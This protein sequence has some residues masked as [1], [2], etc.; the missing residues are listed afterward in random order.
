M[1][2][3]L[4]TVRAVR[5]IMALGAGLSIGIAAAGVLAVLNGVQT[6]GAVMMLYGF[7]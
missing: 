5:C 6:P 3:T 4:S 2:I 7:Y 1:N